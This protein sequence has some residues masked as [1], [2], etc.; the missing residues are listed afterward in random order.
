MSWGARLPL[1]ETDGIV[2]AAPALSR[3]LALDLV[4]AVFRGQPV[5][6]R[7]FYRSGEEAAFRLVTFNRDAGFWLSPLTSAFAELPQLLE[8]GRGAAGGGD[9]V[10]GQ[11]PGPGAHPVHHGHVVPHG[12]AGCAAAGT[13]RPA[14]PR[15][16]ARRRR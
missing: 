4:T 10:R 16:E 12:P 15:D 8:D 11:C 13:A 6:L 1:P 3:S 14:P 7:V 5:W 2:L 9:R